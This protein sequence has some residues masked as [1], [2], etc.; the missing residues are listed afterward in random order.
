MKP[1]REQVVVPQH[2][3][4]R[5]RFVDVPQTRVAQPGAALRLV[6]TA[7]LKMSGESNNVAQKIRGVNYTTGVCMFAGTADKQ[8]RNLLVLC[9][10]GECRD[11]MQLLAIAL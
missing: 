4:G 8:P 7:G 9:G 2:V 10:G 1:Y 3:H 11:L 6:A 5:A